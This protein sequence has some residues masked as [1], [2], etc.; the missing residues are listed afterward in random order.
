ME[1]QAQGKK[2]VKY[3]IKERRLKQKG[4]RSRE[5]KEEEK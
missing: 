1:I 4:E 5:E 3:E 2:Y